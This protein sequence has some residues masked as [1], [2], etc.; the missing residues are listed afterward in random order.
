VSDHLLGEQGILIL[1]LGN[2][3]LRDEGIGVRALEKLQTEYRL[4]PRVRALDGGTMGLDLLPYLAGASKLLILDAL[5]M[6]GRPGSLARLVNGEIPAALALKL[7]V[8]Q[9][10][11]SELL[12]TSRFQGTLPAHVTLLGIEPASIEWGLDFSP[13]VRAAM[14][15]LVEA[16]V[17]ELCAWGAE[18]ERAEL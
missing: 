15:T 6:G 7:S 13:P 3:L 1:G 10:G 17:R 9:V 4:P 14:E 12:A 8:H 18:V 11:L 5:Q 2:I 16:A